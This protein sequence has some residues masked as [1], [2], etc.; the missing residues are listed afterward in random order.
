MLAKDTFWAFSIL[1]GKFQ[2]FKTFSMK[3]W[4]MWISSFLR[5]KN[6]SISNFLP[7]LWASSNIVTYFISSLGKFWKLHSKWCTSRYF[8]HIFISFSFMNHHA[9][10]RGWTITLTWGDEPSPSP[11]PHLRGITNTLTRGDKPSPSL[12]GMNIHPHLSDEPFTLNWGSKPSPSP[13]GINLHPPS[14]EG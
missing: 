8:W 5:L 9:H 4:K 11:H 1:L 2:V 12:N 10:L 7:T 3:M 13:E 14:L 6:I